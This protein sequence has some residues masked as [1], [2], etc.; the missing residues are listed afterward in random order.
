MAFCLAQVLTSAVVDLSA[1]SRANWVGMPS[2]LWV[3]LMFFTR[4]I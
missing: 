1:A 4:T 2:T 3:E